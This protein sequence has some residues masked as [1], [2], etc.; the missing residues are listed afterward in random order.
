MTK[1]AIQILEDGEIVM[2]E[3]VDERH[4]TILSDIV[5]FLQILFQRVIEKRREGTANKA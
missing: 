4:P 1:Y 3:G 5:H 2:E